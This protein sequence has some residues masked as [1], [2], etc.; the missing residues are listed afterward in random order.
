[1]MAETLHISSF[2]HVASQAPF[3]L[4][5]NIE[6]VASKALLCRCETTVVSQVQSFHVAMTEKESPELERLAQ[7]FLAKE[8]WRI[9]L[10]TQ[11]HLHLRNQT[12]ECCLTC[13]VSVP[14]V[15]SQGP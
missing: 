15:A 7:E 11:T 9:E 5:E 8:H 4:L 6:M 3:L 10:S 2:P 12:V 14:T 13:H 1:M